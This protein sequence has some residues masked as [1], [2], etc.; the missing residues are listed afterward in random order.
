MANYHVVKSTKS[1]G[2]GILLTLL[3]GP[4]GLFY[5]SVWG[6]IIMTLGPILF[7]VIFFLGMSIGSE[8]IQLMAGITIIIFWALW[9][10]ICIIWSAVAINQYNR[11]IMSQSIHNIPYYPGSP[12]IESPSYLEIYKNQLPSRE[13]HLVSQENLNDNVPKIQ[14]WLKANPGKGINDYYVKFKK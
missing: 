1:V 8:I 14:D 11:R 13:S 4:I 9:W 6:G 3:L 12:T 10:L 2:V 5:S 7:I